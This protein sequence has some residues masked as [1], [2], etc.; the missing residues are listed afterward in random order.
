MFKE[1]FPSFILSEYPLCK[2]FELLLCVI[3][4]STRLN[5]T[6]CLQAA[7]ARRRCRRS[8]DLGALQVEGLGVLT[9]QHHVL[10]QVPDTPILVVPHAVLL[11]QKP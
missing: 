7:G 5:T 8:P 11:A 4:K 9:Q 2:P 10:L 3:E 6:R 1:P